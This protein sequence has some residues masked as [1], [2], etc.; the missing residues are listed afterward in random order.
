MPHDVAER[1]ARAIPLVKEGAKTML[2]LA[3]LMVFALKTRP[4]R[5]TTRHAP[6]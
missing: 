3:D 1:L 2:E 4:I 5:S 6:C